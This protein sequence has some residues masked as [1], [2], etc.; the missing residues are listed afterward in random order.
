MQPMMPDDVK[1]ARQSQGVFH[2]E[3]D[4]HVMLSVDGVWS[5]MVRKDEEI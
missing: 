4:L 1:A 3:E 5:E 2:D